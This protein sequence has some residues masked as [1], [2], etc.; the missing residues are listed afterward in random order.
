MNNLAPIQA[1]INKFEFKGGLSDWDPRIRVSRDAT[2]DVYNFY[3]SLRVPLVHG[4][5]ERDRILKIYAVS[6]SALEHISKKEVVRFLIQQLYQQLKDLVLHEF[7]ESVWFDG[8][9]TWNH[10]KN[11]P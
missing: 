4:E 7:D 3:F 11:D 5:G 10:Q 6:A 1:L 2:S 9:Q 8:E